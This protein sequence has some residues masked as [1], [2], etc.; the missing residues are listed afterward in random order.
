MGIIRK[1][2][3]H[4][5]I[6]GSFL[7][8]LASN[9]VNFGN[10]L[11]NL[12]MAR[13]LPKEVYGEM[14]ALFSL[15][16]MVGIPLS[17]F[18]IYIIKIVSALYGKKDYPKIR[19]LRSFI[20]PRIV[21]VS[22]LLF[23]LIAVNSLFLAGFLKLSS[24]VP[25]IIIGFNILLGGL[26]AI[27]GAVLTGMLA[28]SY[29]ALNGAVEVILKLLLSVFLVFSGFGLYG[30]LLG[31]S[32][33][34][35]ARLLMSSWELKKLVP[36][37]SVKQFQFSRLK[38]IV[39][40][41]LTMLIL[42]SFLNIDIL[43]V[44]HFFS[45]ARAGE[46]VAL[47]TISKTIL[48]ATG[49]LITVMFPVISNRKSSGLPYL[50]PLLGCLFG[51]ALISLLV[52]MLFSIFPDFVVGILFGGRYATIIPYMVYAAFFM[53]V[54]TL[55][56]ILTY[57][58]LSASFH[59]YIYILA[60]FPITQAVLIFLFHGNIRTVIMVNISVSLLYLLSALI[61]IWR[62][63][64]KNLKILFARYLPAPFFNE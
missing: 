39:P 58:L 40:V 53:A 8:F 10:F 19:Y 11:F 42:V 6:R 46:Y 37:T 9:F 54:F 12:L 49:P 1:I 32:I 45:P 36:A 57:F 29:S 3:S 60:L 22:L 47:T 25:L 16:M 15:S 61:M 27:N 43:L 55:N 59:R 26:S 41:V 18:N 21:A 24:S 33:S 14:G 56:D 4:K 38:D 5:L 2:T 20:F 13:L 44:R 7:V 48:Y 23:A 63:E 17:V 62:S 50:L 31:V 34:A 28:F 52:I 64:A 30:A 35:F 51:S